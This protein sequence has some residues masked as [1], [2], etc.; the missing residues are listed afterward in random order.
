MSMLTPL[1]A[2]GLLAVSLPIIFHLIRRQPR[3]QFEFSSLMFLSPSP[4]RIAKRS[5]LD[6][7]LLLLLRGLALTLLA[8]AFA[9]PFLRSEEPLTPADADAAHVAIVVDTSASMRRGDLSKQATAVVDRAVAD[10]RPSDQ[11]CVL[12]C[13][14]TLRP[15][16]SFEEMSKIAAGERRA[17]VSAHLRDVKPTWAATHL[18]QGLMDAVEIVN[19]VVEVRYRQQHLARRIVLVSD[20]QDGSRLTALA[21]YPWPE[22]VVLDLRPVTSAQKTNAGLHYVADSDRP[23]AAVPPRDVRVRVSNDADSTADEFQLAW[24]DEANKPIG[25]ST[26]AYVPAGESRIVRVPRPANAAAATRLHLTGDSD[27]FDNTIY[28]AA[29]RDAATSVLYIGDDRADDAK[30]L[31]YYLERALTE[32]ASHAVRLATTAANKPLPLDSPTET[33][34]AVVTAEPTADQNE[35]LRSY[36]TS[37]GTVLVVLRESK[38]A[39][40]LAKLVDVPSLEAEEAKL[41]NYTMLGQ[42]DFGHPLFAPMAGPHFND[43]TQIHFW[44]YRRLKSAQLKDAKLVAHLENG[45]PALVEWTIGKGRVYALTSGWQPS[46]SQ[47]ARSWKFVLFVSALLNESQPGQTARAYFTINEPVPLGERDTGTAR[48]AVTKPDGAVVKIDSDAASFPATDQPGIY[49]LSVTNKPQNVAVNLDPLESKTASVGAETVEQWGCRL[50]KPTALA[51][52]TR[53]RQRLQDAQLESRQKW[54]QWLIV[55]AL[56]V[57]VAETWLAGRAAKPAL[58][59]GSPA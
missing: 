59:E 50:V 56:G 32:G 9:R 27:D 19:N 36:V 46:D 43:F 5:K 45:D 16:I 12:S 30:G 57:L 24:I 40:A 21:D 53:Q 14:D 54:W 31:R 48:P 58:S 35:Q 11:V 4:P 44:K 1:Y 29:R 20:M 49:T 28:F 3:G 17:V 41:S 10:L 7:L 13:D 6:H 8:F 39:T 18:G 47:F 26:P 55:G 15:L 37:G 38:D 52:A 34:L 51:D 23:D 33:P 22:D 42:I 25:D 2:L